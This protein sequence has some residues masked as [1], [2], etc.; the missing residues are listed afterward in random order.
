MA[1]GI[2]L[3]SWLVVRVRG[4]GLLNTSLSVTKIMRSTIMTLVTPKVGAKHELLI[5]KPA[6]TRRLAESVVSRQV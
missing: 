4:H 2:L 5:S 6:L 3:L 1:W